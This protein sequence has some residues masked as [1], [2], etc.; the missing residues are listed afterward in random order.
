VAVRF[1]FYSGPPIVSNVHQVHEAPRARRQPGEGVSAASPKLLPF[2]A[3]GGKQ[4]NAL[5]SMTLVLTDV[6]RPCLPCQP[7]AGRRHRRVPQLPRFLL[8]LPSVHP[9]GEGCQ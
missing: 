9:S 3:S 7:A 5:R 1:R 4:R 2:T 8:K 6:L